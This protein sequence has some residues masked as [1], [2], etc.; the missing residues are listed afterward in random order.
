MLESVIDKE[1]A[2]NGAIATASDGEGPTRPRAVIS[3]LKPTPT[4][5]RVERDVIRFLNSMDSAA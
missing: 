2:K 3:L 1:G 5:N 4:R